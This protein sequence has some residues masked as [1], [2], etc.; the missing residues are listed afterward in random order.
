MKNL[1]KLFVV[2]PLVL[3]MLL[4]VVPVNAARLELSPNVDEYRDVKY[5]LDDGIATDLRIAEGDQ[6]D[7]REYIER[8]FVDRDPLP[9]EVMRTVFDQTKFSKDDYYF[10]LNQQVDTYPV[11]VGEKTPI[12]DG[13]HI[14]VI[15]GREY[16]KLVNGGGIDGWVTFNWDVTGPL[17]A[18]Q[19][20]IRDNHPSYAIPSYQ[21]HHVYKVHK[22]VL[23]PETWLLEF[24]QRRSNVTAKVADGTEV[25]GTSIEMVTDANTKEPVW[26][27]KE[28]GYVFNTYVQVW[29]GG[30]KSEAEVQAAVTAR[31]TAAKGDTATYHFEKKDGKI[32][33]AYV[34]MAGIKVDGVPNK[35][36]D[37]ATFPAIYLYKPGDAVPANFEIDEEDKTAT[38][39][40]KGAVKYVAVP[41]S[42]GIDEEDKTA[43]HKKTGDVKYVDGAHAVKQ[44][45]GEKVQQTKIHNVTAVKVVEKS[46]VDKNGKVVKELDPNN[47]YRLV[48]AYVKGYVIIVENTTVPVHVTHHFTLTN[49]EEFQKTSEEVWNF[50]QNGV[51]SVSNVNPAWYMNVEGFEIRTEMTE[52]RNDV[53]TSHVLTM[54]EEILKGYN[55]DLYYTAVEEA[56]GEQNIDA[57]FGGQVAGVQEAGNVNAAAQLPA[58]GAADSLA[59]VLSSVAMVVIGLFLKK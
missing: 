59:V 5:G 31:N 58:T 57:A 43:T 37:K 25:V 34:I 54:G 55:V 18:A 3:V 12:K 39:K 4:S 56:A 10:Y 13:S 16:I 46:V 44:L 2:L 40:E 21:I 7:C 28:G 26:E 8:A 36:G 29:E 15:P 45:E 48:N 41:A 27:T 19:A 49:G 14:T 23:I 50:K 35:D 53:D 24:Q 6:S 22:K 32:V 38:H 52:V 1:K 30:E 17:T 47:K 11:W 20:Y 51:L 9:N 33:S 42:F